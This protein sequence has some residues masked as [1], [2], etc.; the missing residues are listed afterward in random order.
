MISVEEALEKILREVDTLEEE[1]VPILDSQGQVLAEDIKS[2]IN[3]PPL[4]NAA[5]DGY[6][7]KYEDVENHSSGEILNLDV[8]GE[9]A[10]GCFPVGK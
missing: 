8:T 5:M 7:V 9:V 10:A 3:V 4:D 1:S 6:A 2:D